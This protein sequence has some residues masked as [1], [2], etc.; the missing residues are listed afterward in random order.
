MQPRF[1]ANAQIKNKIG[2]RAP[3]VLNVEIK[4]RI[5]GLIYPASASRSEGVSISNK[6]LR[7]GAN[8]SE[9]IS[10]R[11]LQSG[12]IISVDAIRAGGGQIESCKPGDGTEGHDWFNR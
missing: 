6:C 9:F 3:T 10:D 7:Y 2:T 12:Q 8:S 5:G 4:F 11:V 1:Q